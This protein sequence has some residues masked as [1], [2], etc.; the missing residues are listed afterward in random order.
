MSLLE[1]PPPLPSRVERARFDVI[2]CCPIGERT[3]HSYNPTWQGT[4]LKS[5]LNAF[6]DE[7]QD[8]AFNVL[9]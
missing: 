6:V 8:Q 1:P 5:Q 4:S 7:I 9:R 3:E 2:Y